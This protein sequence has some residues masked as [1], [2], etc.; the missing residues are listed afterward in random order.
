MEDLKE[1]ENFP[2]Y[3]VDNMG[4]VFSVKTGVILKPWKINGYNAVGLYKSGKRFVFLV[5][6]LVAEAF[7]CNAENKEQVDHKNGNLTDNRV[8]NLRWATPKENSNNPVTIQKLKKSLSIK[9]H[10]L[11]KALQ[12]Y[13]LDGNFI[14]EW[15]GTKLPSE[16]LHIHRSGIRNCLVGI[17][18]S[19][20]GFIWKYKQ[21]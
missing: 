8:C 20:G 9:P 17:A 12:Q 18:K 11:A 19:A 4:N 13:D 7:I 15:K 3:C 1:I 21:N 14:K 10:Y 5:H 6:R 2:G 16:Q